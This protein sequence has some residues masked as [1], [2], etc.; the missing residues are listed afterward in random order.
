MPT[1]WTWWTI[2]ED[3]H[4]VEDR[5]SEDSWLERHPPHPGETIRYDCLGKLSVGEAAQR[6]QVSRRSLDQVLKGRA[7]VTASLALRLEG[8]GW[9][10]AEFWLRCQAHHDLAV[11]R[12]SKVRAA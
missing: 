7:P 10:N 11:A 3:M 4:V 9:S 1:M 8:L 2:I 6:L 12:R 5:V